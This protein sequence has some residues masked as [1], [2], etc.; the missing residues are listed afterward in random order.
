M[1]ARG[2]CMVDRTAPNRPKCPPCFRAPFTRAL[3]S[4]LIALSLA[5][6]AFPQAPLPPAAETARLETIED[7]SESLANEVLDLSVAVRDR[8]LSRVGA[9]FADSIEAPPFPSAPGEPRP[10][11][12]WISLHGWAPPSGAPP[13]PR[14]I[15]HREFLA[16]FAAFLDHFSEIEDVRFKVRGATFDADARLGGRDAKEPTAAP[17]ASG[18]SDDRV[19][20][21][22]ATGRDGASGRAAARDARVRKPESGPWQ[23]TAFDHPSSSRRLAATDL[24]SEVAAPAGVA[25]DAPALRGARNQRFRLARRGG[26]RRR[27]RRLA[28]PR[29]VTAAD[30]NFLYLGDGKGRFRDVSQDRREGAPASGCGAPLCS[31]STTTAT[32]TSSSPQWARRSCSRTA[33]S[34]GALRFHDVSLEMGVAV[35]GDRLLA[36][37]PPT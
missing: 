27:R 2:V 3:V 19:L 17:G 22:G 31:T 37:P 15:P 10:Q 23:F 1:P 24:F 28:G 20:L 18:S 14:P 5:S 16:S 30:R 36:P 12:K 6:L 13:D 32:S 29:A 11:V 21:S 9:Y 26:G 25:R 35:D 4:G 8:D 33:W 34:D 7:L